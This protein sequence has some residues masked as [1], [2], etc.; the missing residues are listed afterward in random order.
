MPS[1][2]SMHDIMEAVAHTLR[3][4][5]ESL[6]V[7]RTFVRLTGLRENGE[8]VFVETLCLWHWP[9]VKG[10]SPVPVRWFRTGNTYNDMMSEEWERYGYNNPY[11]S[12]SD[13]E[14]ELTLT[15]D[16]ILSVAAKLCVRMKKDILGVKVL[17]PKD[18]FSAVTF[19]LSGDVFAGTLKMG[20]IVPL[21]VRTP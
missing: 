2:S 3:I 11:G 16:I 6:A 17:I 14:R 9:A 20:R 7:L 8:P 15:S 5:E 1:L 10:A 13:A 19:T 18:A 21:Q 4:D 12:P